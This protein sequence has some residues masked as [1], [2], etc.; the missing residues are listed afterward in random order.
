MGVRSQKLQPI[1][2]FYY[3]DYR[4]FLKDC[5]DQAH[6]ADRKFSHRYLST[7][8]GTSSSGWF[9]DLIKGRINLQ[10]AQLVKLAGLFKLTGTQIDYFETL[11]QFN[12]AGSL[13]ER[14]RHFR[15]LLCFREMKAES[16][17]E[18]R[19][20]YYSK[21]YYSALRELLFFHDFKGDFTALGKRLNPPIKTSQ[22][23]EGILLLEKLGFI[24][25]DAQGC[26]RPQQETVKKVP[27]F[28]S[29][30]AVNYLNA[31]MELAMR[32][33]E[34]VPKEQRHIS[35]LTLS[36]SESGFQKALEEVEC[37]RKK[38]VG[39]M[40]VDTQPDKVFQINLQIFPVTR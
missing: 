7:K 37:L 40:E 11:V 32:A 35:A 3:S 36:F 20:E 22:A 16:V 8:V 30:Y 6:Q 39:L 19:F 28:K 21:W 2:I 34:S 18:E 27:S 10:G 17:G 5:Y 15:K 4:A 13:E 26:F 33:L 24:K 14:N 9:S 38:L 29:L 25:K 1:S 31:N 12:Q 23:K